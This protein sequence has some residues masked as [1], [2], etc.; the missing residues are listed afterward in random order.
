[1]N[2]PSKGDVQRTRERFPIG[3]HVELIRIDPDPYSKLK[4]GDR[5][6]VKSADDIGTVFASRD[7]GSGPG[8]VCGEDKIRRLVSDT[9]P[10]NT[11]K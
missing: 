5:S 11:G 6:T 3:C 2:F 9:G 10:G 1:M 4:P 7:C 8:V